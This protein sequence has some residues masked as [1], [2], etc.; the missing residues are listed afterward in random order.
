VLNVSVFKEKAKYCV[1]VVVELNCSGIRPDRN[2][3][4]R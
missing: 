4:A 3:F 2:G 1:H